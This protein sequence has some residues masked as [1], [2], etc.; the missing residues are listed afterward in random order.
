MAGAGDK[1]V[2]CIIHV[3]SW[4]PTR[5]QAG[6]GESSV[7]ICHPKII[8]VYS[9]ISF[10]DSMNVFIAELMS[11]PLKRGRKTQN[12]WP[13]MHEN[14]F[15]EGRCAKWYK[16]ASNL[17]VLD[18]PAYIKYFATNLLLLS[19]HLQHQ[20]DNASSGFPRNNSV[21][22]SSQFTVDLPDH[23]SISTFSSTHRSCS[24]HLI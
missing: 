9:L 20:P 12:I 14:L 23:Q 10:I 6:E 19:F 7:V 22:S 2:S 17:N 15:I 18:K 8:S 4:S 21:L 1:V 5:P 16:S 24:C 3:H 13:K 11:W